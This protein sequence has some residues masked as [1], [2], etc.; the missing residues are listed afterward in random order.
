[1][2]RFSIR[3]IGD[4][5]PI[6]MLEADYGVFQ[7]AAL[8]ILA[9]ADTDPVGGWKDQ[10]GFGRNP[11]STGLNR[12]VLKLGV[13]GIGGKPALLF[14]GTQ[15]LTS[16]A[17]PAIVSQPTTIYAVVQF[18][19]ILAQYGI[20]DG[21]VAGSRHLIYSNVT[22]PG[23]Y[24]IYSGTT[25]TEATPTIDTNP[26]ILTARF[27]GTNSGFWV[28]GVARIAGNAG[29]NTLTGL[30]IG[31]AF[32]LAVNLFKGKIA[33]VRIYNTAHDAYRRATIIEPFRIKY[34]I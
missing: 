6:E 17:F 34:G 8:T 32:T 21:I 31:A 19:D 15:Y 29:T 11:A 16:I 14:S 25:I 9:V 33:A 20:V 12:P 27:N 26:H 24:Q 10:S 7:D 28:D 4:D 13:N 18:T 5:Q 2:K 1:M 23:K 22:D 3:L 30:T